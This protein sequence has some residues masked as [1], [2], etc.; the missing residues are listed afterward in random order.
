MIFWENVEVR[1]GVGLWLPYLCRCTSKKI[2]RNPICNV[3]FIHLK[4]F[5][6]KHF[7]IVVKGE[8][9]KV[10]TAN[11]GFSVMVRVT[12]KLKLNFGGGQ[13]QWALAMVGKQREIN[14]LE[15]Q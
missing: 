9:R 8:C 13:K 7:D 5:E 4:M 6:L 2:S 3:I 14:L 1:P 12:Q 10:L 15:T 11:V